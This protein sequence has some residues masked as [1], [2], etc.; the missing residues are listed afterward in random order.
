MAFTH[1][2]LH[3]DYSLLDSMIKIP[4]LV[5][6]IKSLGMTS[7]AIT[8]HGTAAGIVEFYNACKKEGI[9]PILGIEAYEAPASRFERKNDENPNNY[10]HLI[11]LVKNEQGYK[12][13]CKL[14][15]RSNTE[16]FYYKPRIDFELLEQF[17][18]GLICMSACIA[19]RVQ[20]DIVAGDIEKAEQDLLRYKNLFG[21]DYY[22]EIQNH[23]IPEE[24]IVAQKFI[25]FSKKYG[26]KFICTNDCH[27]LNSEDAKAHEWMVCIQTGKKL[28]DENRLLYVGDY[29]VK[30]EEDMR[31]LYPYL[32]EAF[33]NTQEI[34]EKCNFDF[35]FGEYKMP[36]VIVPDS[37][38][39]SDD[40]DY[41]TGEVIPS[42][43]KTTKY[44]KYLKYLA[45]KG[46]EEKYP[47]G[48]PKREDAIKRLDY[49]LS[50]IKQMGYSDYFLDTLKTIEWA[51]N[52]GILVGPGRGCEIEGEP[53]FTSKGIKN[54]E[55]VKIGDIVFDCCGNS[56]AVK[57]VFKYNIDEDIYEINVNYGGKINFT[58]D[59]KFLVSPCEYETDKHLLAQGYAFKNKIPTNDLE[60][61]PAS[62]LKKGDW[63]VMPIIKSD[64]VKDI[65][66]DLIQY[67]PDDDHF[68]EDGEYLCK[69]D[70][71]PLVEKKVGINQI[72]NALGMTKRTVSLRLNDIPHITDNE[73]TKKIKNYLKEKDIDS[74]IDWA[75]LIKIVKIPRSISLN[76]DLAYLIGYFIADGW[77]HNQETVF[78]YNSLT[79][80]NYKNIIIEKLRKVFGNDVNITITVGRGNCHIINVN[81]VII[82]SFFNDLIKG[83]SAHTK[84]IPEAINCSSDG[85]KEAFLKGAF[86]GD[87]SYTELYRAKYTTVNKQLA[88]DIKR[89]LI[90][91]KI[92]SN[93]KRA[94]RID[95]FTGKEMVIYDVSCP[96]TDKSCEIFPQ[97]H[98]SPYNPS[99][100]YYI[101]DNY[102][103]MR[104]KSIKEYRYKGNVY[105]ISVDTDS[106]PS[107]CTTV[108]AVHNSGAGSVLNYCIGIT[109]LEPLKYGLLFERFLNP[110]RISMPDIDV[111]YNYS[112]KD[113]VV[114]SEAESNGKEHFA[115]IQTFMTMA[116]KGVIKDCVRVAG[117]EPSVGNKFSKMIGKCK[118]LNEAYDT[119]PEI[120]DY[121]KTDD[122]IRELWNIA[123]KLENLK[124]SA[125]THACGHIPTYEKCE[126][127]FPC[128]VDKKTGYLVCQYDMVEAE[129]LGNLKK[130]L[131]ML[132]NLDVI[133]V[134]HKAVKERHGV[135]IPLWTDE[136]LNNKKALALFSSGDTNG[137]FQFESEGMKKFMKELK[138]DCFE[139][140]IAG[141]SLYRPGPMDFI[142][143]YVEGKHNPASIHYLTPELEPIL[144]NT[145][146]CIVY[147]EQVMQIVRALAGF[148]MGRSDLVRKAMG[149]KKLDI[150]EQEGKNFIY[151]N[152]ELNIPGCINDGISEETA[153]TLWNQMAEFAKYAFNKSHAAC[154]AAISMQTAYLKANYPLEFYA[155][156]LSSV[157]DDTPSLS[158]YLL[159]CKNKNIEIVPPDINQSELS[160]K[161]LSDGRITFGLLALKGLGKSKVEAIIDE[162]NKNGDYAGLTDFIN[163]T[164]FKKGA[165]EPLIYSGAFDGFG[166]SRKTLITNL[167][168]IIAD[169]KREK[170]EQVEG[171]LDLFSLCG[172]D[173]TKAD[174]FED[175]P[176]FSEDDI[177]EK[178]ME[179]CGI[180]ISGHP[181][182][183]YSDLISSF[184]YT[185][186]QIAGVSNEESEQATDDSS[187]VYKEELEDGTPV[188]VLG[189]V[190]EIRQIVTKKNDLMAFVTLSGLSADISITI[191]P[192][193]YA[194][195]KEKLIDGAILAIKGTLNCDSDYGNAVIAD[196][197][198]RPEDL[199]R[200]LWLKFETYNDFV[201]EQESI[202]KRYYNSNPRSNIF[203]YIAEAKKTCM[204]PYS[205]FNYTEEEKEYLINKYGTDNVAVQYNF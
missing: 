74:F 164:D 32:P 28:S 162:R 9:K 25:E 27:Y 147:Q 35:T 14:V 102:I 172:G 138:P 153:Q 67:L 103:Y 78:A 161:V 31:S 29:S 13:L 133:E 45:F 112:H 44:Y 79:E 114:D 10:Y 152:T 12:N 98:V 137:I 144:K 61:L 104:I 149:K 110:E 106:E 101:D 126:D 184:K 107:Y 128:S 127:L 58:K 6:K 87:G 65:K 2:H 170:K 193:T 40:V 39:N 17:H 191:F 118:S 194:L 55:D 195:Y 157:M 120:E 168:T 136:I 139:D 131:L 180:Y 179:Y 187:E 142:P 53:I 83:Q 80:E 19:G 76:K 190:K 24:T 115:K 160:F 99:P 82:S 8:D 145:Y 196:V 57:E 52:H 119:N 108:C 135:D 113:E 81:S 192:K 48:N 205:Y 165:T 200:K 47:E 204:I 121:L 109:D 41:I 86:D 84:Q 129:H 150:M 146:G 178:E 90:G 94:A 130:D 198:E 93:V 96:A 159:D 154:Y 51:R 185:E 186:E 100:S 117:Y 91:L 169:D 21:D 54:I 49:E 124:K 171:Q 69:M 123:L 85:I 155:G 156:L 26:I 175:M 71:S 88:Y 176:E 18:E 203:C 151:G 62:E 1:L 68:F 64:V 36:K 22:L 75:N 43:E 163:R 125:S 11:L 143:Q 30:S 173:I 188:K 56:S 148:S 4:E 158:K 202:Q 105:D 122:S 38:E 59:H 3:T 141:V 182:Y 73:T 72:K 77:T 60:W 50:V 97:L 174:S 183:K 34:V 197:I 33:D 5:K 66:Y 15:S 20:R 167:P 46:L 63:L 132:R 7:C 92:P 189:I 134:A 42:D 177:L 199:T 95:H 70:F 89:I 116:A 16:G 201:N 37:F 181:L 166:Y 140:T 111:D 23:G